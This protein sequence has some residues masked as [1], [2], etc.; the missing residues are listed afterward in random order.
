MVNLNHGEK[1]EIE[2]NFSKVDPPLLEDVV[3]EMRLVANKLMPVTYPKVKSSTYKFKTEPLK[4]RHIVVDG[5]DLVVYFNRSDY[6]ACMVESLEIGGVYIPF[7]PMSLVCKVGATFLGGYELKYA[8]AFKNG[9]KVY[10]WTVA[11]DNHG[12]P[13]VLDKDSLKKG[14]YEG[15]S[16]FYIPEELSRL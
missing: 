5:Y 9:R 14:I 15:F 16:F 3:S 12:R 7:L 8:E 11:I 6:K 10:L 4:Q 1:P 13:I 2:K